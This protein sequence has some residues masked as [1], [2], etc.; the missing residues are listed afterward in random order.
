MARRYS[1][2]LTIYVTLPLSGSDTCPSSENERY[3]C[4]VTQDGARVGDVLIGRVPSERRADDNPSVIDETARSALAFLE[5]D[6]IDVSDAESDAG[7][8]VRR[9]KDVRK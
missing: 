4:V 3:R 9:M 8:I 6:G 5:N 1:G 2:A 7:Y